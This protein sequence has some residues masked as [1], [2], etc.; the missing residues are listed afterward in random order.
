MKKNFCIRSVLS[1]TIFVFLFSVASFSV[2]AADS[3]PDITLK[4]LDNKPFKISDL[5]GEV[6]YV[7]FWATW[8][9]PCRKSFPWMEEMHNKY[10][11][12]GFKVIA[13]SLDN[14]R[15]VIDQFLNTMKT[16]FTIVH[17][18][19]GA[20]AQKFKVKGMPSSYLIDR[21]GNIQVR[22]MGFNSKDKAK[23]EQQIK[24]LIATD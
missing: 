5:K 17:D 21:H 6:V 8:C 2:S 19:S 24:D 15:G 7:D 1:I 23:L 12:L 11:D 13:I 10:S 16:S 22:H 20:S 18:P 4:T 9:P 3:A 14:K